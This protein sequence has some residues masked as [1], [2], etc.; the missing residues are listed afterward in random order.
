MTKAPQ[1][2]LAGTWGSQGHGP[3]SMQLSI[4]K[5][6]AERVSS[7]LPT[8]CRDSS[9]ESESRLLATG[10]CKKMHVDSVARDLLGRV[11]CPPSKFKTFH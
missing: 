5:D 9:A 2:R 6:Q 8:S 4:R 7:S 11:L 1:F 10:N 3:I